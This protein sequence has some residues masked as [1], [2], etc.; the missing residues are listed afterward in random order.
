MKLSRK[1]DQ[2]PGFMFYPKDWLT[3]IN[4]CVCSPGAQ[5]LWIRILSHMW[6]SPTR[7]KLPGSL[8]MIASIVGWSSEV[9]GPLL[10]ELR[11]NHVL[12]IGD[13]GC[14][15]SRRMYREWKQESGVSDARSKAGE[16]GAKSRW[17]N[18]GKTMANDG[19]RWQ[20]EDGKTKTS[21]MANSES[22]RTL[23]ASEDTGLASTEENLQHGKRD[24]KRITK[25]DGKNGT[26]VSVSVSVSESPSEE[27]E[28]KNADKPSVE[29]REGPTKCGIG[30]IPSKRTVT[31][32]LTEIGRFERSAAWLGWWRKWLNG[33]LGSN[34][35][36][37]TE[38]LDALQYAANCADPLKRAQ[39]G[40]G[41]LRHPDR[42]LT[43]RM[44]DF[45]R[46]RG[47]DWPR[48]PERVNV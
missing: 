22:R 37:L 40:I 8:S 29:A 14:I 25:V 9:V 23:Q 38:L 45:A 6:S 41:P 28:H 15:Y 2:R 35:D 1:M 13:D 19:K 24:G 5:G 26:S 20:N 21:A 27:I 30:E 18:D 42:Y 3:D 32:W 36:G 11:A 39:M 31:E 10:E 43:G 44:T 48:Y 17:Q 12:T 4:L 46:S 7:G 47:I 34:P 16:K 33:A